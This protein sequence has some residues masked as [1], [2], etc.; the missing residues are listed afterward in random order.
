[1]SRL[2]V[3]GINKSYGPQHVLR[4]VDL[5]FEDGE[6]V[7]LLGPSGCGKTTLL[8]IIAG[9]ETA[10]SG[11]IELDGKDISATPPNRRNMGMVF[12]A[13]SLFPNMSAAENVAFGLRVR[14][15]AKRARNDR[16]AELLDLVGLAAF[17]HKYPHQL[18]GGQQQRV[19]LARALAIRPSLLLL[20]EPLSALDARV[21]VQLR[22]EIRRIQQETGVTTVFVTHDQEEAL[23]ISDRVAVMSHGVVDQFDAP[24]AIYQRPVTAFVAGFIGISSRLPGA[25]A[26]SAKGLVRV[27]GQTMESE[28]ARKMADGAPVTVYLRPEDVTLLPPAKA[29][30]SRWRGTVRAHTFMGAMTRV[31][32]ALGDE[33]GVLADLNTAD[34]STMPPGSEVAVD[35]AG[36]RAHILPG[37]TDA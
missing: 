6:L 17:A 4:D 19:A 28:A 13:Y 10:D 33:A 23:S 27:A 18:S 25:V 26:D 1:M 35:W 8:R 11:S 31:Q 30:G 16:V 29:N 34:A 14:G 3:R 2:L 37:H 32:V 21:R 12:Q 9:L 24:L 5:A 20:D 36:A 7:T 15:E 22:D